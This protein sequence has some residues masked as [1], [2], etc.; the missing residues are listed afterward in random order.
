MTK[1]LHSMYDFR[2]V[3]ISFW[4][5]KCL[6]KLILADSIMKCSDSEKERK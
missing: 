6:T 2:D 3:V 4:G 1:S 5:K